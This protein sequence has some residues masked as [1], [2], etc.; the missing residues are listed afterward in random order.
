[1]KDFAA[2]DN[3]DTAI[4]YGPNVSKVAPEFGLA[5]HSHLYNIKTPRRQKN[6]IGNPDPSSPEPQ[7]T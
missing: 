6:T 4:K 2:S 3:G 7:D 5:E 1:M